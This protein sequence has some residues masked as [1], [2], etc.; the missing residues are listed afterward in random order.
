MNTMPLKRWKLARRRQMRNVGSESSLTTGS[1]VFDHR[2]DL[3]GTER[4]LQE[5]LERVQALE[6]AQERV[7]VLEGAQ[8]R[9][10][11]LEGALEDAHDR[12]QVLEE[13]LEHAQRAA[14]AKAGGGARVAIARVLRV[15]MDRA[16]LMLRLWASVA[17]GG[18]GW[19]G[20]VGAGKRRRG[21]EAVRA[22]MEGWRGDT[23]RS[24]R[25]DAY[26]GRI[27]GRR[28][29][30]LLHA[31]RGEAGRAKER[32]LAASLFARRTSGV[33]ASGVI[34]AWAAWRRSALN[35]RRAHAA[36]GAGSRRMLRCQ[37][38]TWRVA[39][40]ETSLGARGAVIALSSLVGSPCLED[41]AAVFARWSKLS[42]RAG[43]RAR[44]AGLFR[45]RAER[46]RAVTAV[47]VWRGYAK[48]AYRRV[49]GLMKVIAVQARRR[50][51]D[52]LV[53]CVFK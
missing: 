39:T 36:R 19:E 14:T 31:W 38:A 40:R 5:A 49:V 18:G 11:V 7:H 1:L 53:W 6:Q 35:R 47:L 28:T 30:R 52:A 3:A 8:E 34:D 13:A 17:L 26:L 51:R 48:A 50:A 29:G 21:R 16:K 46:A 25:A 44:G 33:R 45:R 24:R 43:E 37:M 22:C 42:A 32:D 12:S 10:H 23:A 20:W 41:A 27:G 9:A 2:R 15:E 4:R